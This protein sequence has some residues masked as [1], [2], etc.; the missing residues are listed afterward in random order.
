MHMTLIGYIN[1]NKGVVLEKSWLRAPPWV[2][3]K[4]SCEALLD[5]QF[6]PARTF[7]IIF[8]TVVW[9]GLM[10]VARRIGRSF[11]EWT[12]LEQSVVGLGEP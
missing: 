6:R 4:V 1:K 2:E 5:V 7:S 3:Y 9:I 11:V 12:M 8:A 10:R